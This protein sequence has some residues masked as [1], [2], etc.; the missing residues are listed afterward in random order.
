MGI[1]SL[2]DISIDEL[3]GIE[4]GVKKSTD[5]LFESIT[6]YDIDE[7]KRY[8]MKFGGANSLVLSG[9][10]GEKIRVRLVSNTL[11]TLQNDFKVKID[12]ISG[13]ASMWM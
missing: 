9:Y 3:L 8:D 1:S 13:N 4:K 11:S 6:E 7:V 12:T 5:Y 10:D 2:F